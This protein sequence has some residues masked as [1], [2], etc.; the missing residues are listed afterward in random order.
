MHVPNPLGSYPLSLRSYDVPSPRKG[1]LLLNYSNY[2]LYY[3]DRYTG[4]II[5]IAEN[6]YREI[7]KAKVQN[8][9]VKICD[10]DKQNPIPPRSEIWPPVSEREFHGA[11]IVIRSR[12]TL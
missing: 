6:I 2:Y 1:E 9:V 12:S 3:C 4:K 8:T 7:L 11:Y 5:P 10:A